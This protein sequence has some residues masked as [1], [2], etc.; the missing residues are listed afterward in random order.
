MKLK[1]EPTPGPAVLFDLPSQDIRAITSRLAHPDD[2]LAVWKAEFDDWVKTI[3]DFR[4]FEE[5]RLLRVEKPTQRDLRLHRWVLHQLMVAGERLALRLLEAQDLPE[6]LRDKSLSHVDVFVAELVDRW[7][8][9]HREVNP[10]HRQM[11]AKFLT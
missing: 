3:V 6:G 10:A 5:E 4:A 11:L 8:S 2:P 9:W 1:D 7:D